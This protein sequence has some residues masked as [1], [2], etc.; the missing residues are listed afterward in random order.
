LWLTR[1]FVIALLK[2]INK[3]AQGGEGNEKFCC[4]LFIDETKAKWNTDSRNIY[5]ANE[6]I[7]MHPIFERDNM[8]FR[9]I[10]QNDWCFRYFKNFKINFPENLKPTQKSKSKFI[11]KLETIAR[12]MQL[13]VMQGKKTSEITTK[14]VIHFNKHDHSE[15]I[16]STYKE[17]IKDF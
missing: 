9:F 3:Y 4:N 1:G 11:D 7:S 2:I 17:N 8:Y 16:L 15:K 5:I 12:E 13:K 14:T 10:K 6:I